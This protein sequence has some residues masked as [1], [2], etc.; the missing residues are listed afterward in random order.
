MTGFLNYL[1]YTLMLESCTFVV[2]L[3]EQSNDPPFNVSESTLP[4]KLLFLDKFFDFLRHFD[5]E[6]GEGEGK[7]RMHPASKYRQPL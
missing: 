1:L 4:V 2:N 3:E 6:K 5:T 7:K